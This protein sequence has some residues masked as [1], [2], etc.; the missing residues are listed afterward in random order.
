MQ[1]HNI[2]DVYHTLKQRQTMLSGQSEDYQKG[3]NDAVMLLRSGIG[4][5]HDAV[6]Y[7]LKDRE[8]QRY[9]NTIEQKYERLHWQVLFLKN[10]LQAV[11]KLGSIDEREVKYFT[12][13]YRKLIADIN[14]IECSIMVLATPEQI[15]EHFTAAAKFAVAKKLRKHPHNTLRC[16]LMEYYRSIGFN[17]R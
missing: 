6:N 4:R 7:A 8:T 11:N 5:C 15:D 17:C 14:G 12:D 16:R 1:D 3:F 2:L 10:K 13:G 9:V